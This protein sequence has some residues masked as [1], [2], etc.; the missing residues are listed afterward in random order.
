MEVVNKKE[1]FIALEKA[2]QKDDM[3]NVYRE[4][5]RNALLDVKTINEH[6][7]DGVCDKLMNDL[8]DYVVDI[9]YSNLTERIIKALEPELQK[10]MFDVIEHPASN[11]HITIYELREYLEHVEKEIS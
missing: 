9:R 1:V 11:M 8:E 5:I 2:M 6:I 7:K 4:T 3:P 10:I